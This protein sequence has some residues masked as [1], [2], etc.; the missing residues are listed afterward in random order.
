MSCKLF[1]SS[2]SG[3]EFLGFIMQTMLF[4]VAMLSA[5]Q[6]GQVLTGVLITLGML[7]FFLVSGCYFRLFRFRILRR[8]LREVH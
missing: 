1:L 8:F 2:L 5:F 6:C 3:L 4:F 7:G